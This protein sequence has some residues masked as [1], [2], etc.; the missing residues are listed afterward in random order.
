MSRHLTRAAK[1][2]LHELLVDKAQQRQVCVT[3]ANRGVVKSGPADPGQFA[4][5]ENRKMRVIHAHQLSLPHHTYRPKAFAK[6]SR[7]ATSL[8]ILACSLAGSASLTAVESAA[9][10]E[11]VAAVPKTA[12]HFQAASIVR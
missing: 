12:A 10:G 6:K 1:W 2:R 4:L 8:P 5:P 11:N 7:S 3:L 9:F